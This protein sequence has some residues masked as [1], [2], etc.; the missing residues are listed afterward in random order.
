[1]YA[2]ATEAEI[3]GESP[4]SSFFGSPPAQAMDHTDC[5]KPAVLLVG[6]GDWPTVF[7]PSPRTNAIVFPSGEKW[8]SDRGWPSSVSYLVSW[9]TRN[10]GVSALH[11]FLRPC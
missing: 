4:A 7:F 2:T 6:L 3:A 11:I 10:P 5:S 1:M 8:R 9:R